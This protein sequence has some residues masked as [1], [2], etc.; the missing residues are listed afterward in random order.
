VGAGGVAERRQHLLELG[1]G[2]VAHLSVLDTETAELLQPAQ[3]LEAAVGYPSRREIQNLE[4]AEPLQS[5]EPVVCDRSMYGIQRRQTGQM[6]DRRKVLDRGPSKDEVLQPGHGPQ[7]DQTGRRD[8]SRPQVQAIHS[9]QVAQMDEASASDPRP[10]QSQVFQRRQFLEMN[11]VG[12]AEVPGIEQLERAQAS[13]TSAS[14]TFPPSP[15]IF[16]SPK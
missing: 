7:A 5:G 16:T 13:S 10:P 15:T 8:H 11:Q 14:F 3:M 9:D 6:T 4:I 12:V 2:L 1:K